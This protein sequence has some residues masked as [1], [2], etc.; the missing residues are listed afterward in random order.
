MLFIAILKGASFVDFACKLFQHNNVQ[1]VFWVER[2]LEWM[3][4]LGL[5]L[6]LCPEMQASIV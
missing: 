4:R 1:N 3:L 2:F 5:S 6:H